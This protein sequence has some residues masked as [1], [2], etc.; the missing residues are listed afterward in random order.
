MHDDDIPRRERTTAEHD[1]SYRR[2]VLDHVI[3]R[4]PAHLRVAELVLEI[5]A[6]REREFEGSDAIERA[7]RDLTG[8]GLL[9]CPSA[10]V[11]PTNA[12]LCFA[13]LGEE[14]RD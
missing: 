3:Y 12:A 6:G 2:A 10:V 5:T 4:H 14:D 7:I 13:E 1:R 11:M 9:H 8:A